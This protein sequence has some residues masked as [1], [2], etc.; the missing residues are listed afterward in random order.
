MLILFEYST[1][2]ETTF[3]FCRRPEKM[4]F[5]KK[6]HWNFM[7]YQE[8]WYFIFPEIWSYPLNEK[9]ISKKTCDLKKKYIWYF[10]QM[11]WKDCLFKKL[12]WNMISCIIWKDRI[13]FPENVIFF[14]WTGGE[15][16]SFSRNTWRCDI[17][18]KYVQVLQTWHH[19]SLP[20]KIKYDFIPQKYA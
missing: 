15:R 3:S 5:P 2:R 8:R 4:V 1:A 19:A 7:Y 12:R 6:L 9:K 16:R 20:K 13:F 17:L 18:C 10:L 11:F 14:L